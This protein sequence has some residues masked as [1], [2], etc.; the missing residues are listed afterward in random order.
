MPDNALT[1][2]E[3]DLLGYAKIGGAF[4][5]LIK[6]IDD[7]KV[8]S[9]EASFGQGKTY[10]RRNW[11]AQ[12]RAAGEVVVEF[13]AQESDRTGDPL[14]TLLGAMIKHVPRDEPNKWK[15]VSSKAKA[16]AGVAARSAV[17]LILRNGAEEVISAV[18]NGIDEKLPEYDILNKT[19]EDMETSLSKYAATIID[20]QLAAEKAVQELPTQLDALKTALAGNG[21][22][23]VLIDELDRC[24]PEYAIA[25][26][27][28]M[29]LVFN[30]KGYV[31]CLMVN[32]QYLENIAQHRFGVKVDGEAYLDKFI[33]LRLALRA[34]PESVE[35]ATRELALSL[36]LSIP[37]GSDPEF[38][39]ARAAELAAKLAVENNFSIRQIKRVLESVEL[40]LRIYSSEPIDCALLVYLAFLNARGRQ[41]D[42]FFGQSHLRRAEL[43]AKKV[44]GFGDLNWPMNPHDE[45]AARARQFVIENCRELMGLDSNRYPDL[46]DSPSW[47]Q[48]YD[49]YKVLKGLGPSYIPRH[50][51]LL[52]MVHELQAGTP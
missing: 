20:S 21:R 5:N 22:I 33:E 45:L 15:D 24:H 42:V 46:E 3:D 27:E 35:F 36:P 1:P 12:L 9:I 18:Q 51:R 49:W 50:E 32:P 6:S 7:T 44:N 14:V 40:A 31:F 2:W 11:A 52:E 34:T 25:L 28:A 39:V 10:F 19:M 37:F 4:T 23:V 30:R 13:D 16:L 26:L 48:F 41:R 43:T 29:K 38:S 8:I 17:K 47:K